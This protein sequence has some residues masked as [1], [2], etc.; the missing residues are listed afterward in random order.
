MNVF[1]SV[2]LSLTQL[3][4]NCLKNYHWLRAM[5]DQEAVEMPVNEIYVENATIS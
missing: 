4:T 3:R 1:L 5:L 2:I